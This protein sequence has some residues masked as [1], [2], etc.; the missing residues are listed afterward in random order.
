[1]KKPRYSPVDDEAALLAQ[2][3][4]ALSRIIEITKDE[5]KKERCWSALSAVN[6]I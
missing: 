5:A 6:Q 2:A 1:M 4:A 3:K